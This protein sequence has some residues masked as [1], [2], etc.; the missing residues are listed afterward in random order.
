M[1]LIERSI[2]AAILPGLR[3]PTSRPVAADGRLV[4]DRLAWPYII[5]TRLRGTAWHETTGGPGEWQR[6]IGVAVE[7]GN[8][9]ADMPE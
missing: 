1:F 4:R 8:Y 6:E 3:L 5:T 7:L 2:H 9:R